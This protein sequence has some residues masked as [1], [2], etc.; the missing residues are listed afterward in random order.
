MS[1]ETRNCINL[2]KLAEMIGNDEDFIREIL[3]DFYNELNILAKRIEQRLENINDDR[4]KVDVHTLKGLCGNVC[5]QNLHEILI[6]VDKALK[7]NNL[8]EASHN[9]GAFLNAKKFTERFL[10][11]YLGVESD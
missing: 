8:E 6:N 4:I 11:N 7:T 1:T 3:T 10:M 9:L 5:A 2:E